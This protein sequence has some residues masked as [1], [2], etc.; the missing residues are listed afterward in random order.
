VLAVDPLA[1][2]AARTIAPVL[3]LLLLC[4]TLAAAIALRK[5]EVMWN[6]EARRPV[7]LLIFQ[8]VIG[9]LMFSFSLDLSMTLLMPFMI[10][11]YSPL[12]L[13]SQPVCSARR[14]TLLMVAT[15][16]LFAIGLMLIGNLIPLSL[17]FRV[18]PLAALDRLAGNP[19]AALIPI[20]KYIWYQIPMMGV[21][22]IVLAFVGSLVSLRQA[23]DTENL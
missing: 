17:L 2:G 12:W 7:G 22:V 18:L 23:R 21:Y 16:G 5:Y 14:V 20:E 11:F 15:L 8:S 9:F 3:T 19:P 6:N 10:S 4:S 13:F 1:A